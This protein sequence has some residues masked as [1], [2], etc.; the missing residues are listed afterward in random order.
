MRLRLALIC[1]ACLALAAPA[2]APA[3]AGLRRQ[4]AKRVL[5]RAQAVRAG[6]GVK[7]GFELT[8]LLKELATRLGDLPARDRA[9][10]R[11]LME[12]PTSGAAQ[13]GEDEYLVPEHTPLCSLHFCVHWVSTTADAPPPADANSDGV[14]DYVATLSEVMEHVH[15]VEN[16]ELGWREPV[17]DGTR[18]DDVDKTDVYLKELGDQGIFGYSTPDPNQKGNS[19]FAYLVLDNDFAQSEF[20][21]YP[22]FVAP[23]EVT[24]AHEYNHILQ[25]GYDWLQDTWMFEATAVWAEDR[26][27]DAVNDYRSYLPQWTHL[28]R[29]PLTAYDAIDPSNPA[30]IKVYGD[31]VWNRWIEAHYGQE[32]IRQAWERSLATTPRSFAPA[33]Y[34]AALRLHGTT[35]LSAFTR[36]VADTAEW[37]SSASAFEEGP[38][39]PDIP[40]GRTLAM[41]STATAQLDH[42]AYTLWNVAPTGAARIK[43]IGTL[44]AGTAG[45]FALVGRSGS[46]TGGALE[47]EIK[48]LPSGGRARVELANP[49]R[50]ARITAVLVNAAVTQ[51]GFFPELG[52]WDF[53]RG[54]DQQ[55][56]ALLSN[57]FTPPAVVARKPTVGKQSASRSVKPTVAFSEPVTGVSSRSLRLLDPAGQRV[58]ATVGYDPS[59]RRAT[60]TPKQRLRAHTHYDVELTI[61][62]VDRGR[63]PVAAADRAWGFRT[64]G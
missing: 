30:N 19:Q 22:D 59:T 4:E 23:M 16:G 54:D 58:P 11:R 10:G 6:H 5:E 37:R 32:T 21:R 36:F 44:P 3:A 8:P 45:A 52:D 43:L 50:F 51:D 26:V 18:G 56:Q 33:A 39:W 20:P 1:A 53:S 62:I 9:R 63:N 38:T 17:G 2:P 57:D 13:P 27:Y 64:G 41:N 61:G 24:A 28:T 14:P 46:P 55:V 34:D 25:F 31:A 29:T 47:V 49:S 48:R 40:R 12:R 35:F 7:T 15:D 60:L 42:T